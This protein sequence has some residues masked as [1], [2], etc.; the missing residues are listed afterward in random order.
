MRRL[1][2]IARDVSYEDALRE[3]LL[4]LTNEYTC[5]YA[6]DESRGDFKILLPIAGD[7]FVLDVGC[8]WGAVA[9]SLARSCGRLVAADT[10]LETLEFLKI[11]AEQEGVD[12]IT[13]IRIDPLDFAN[14]PFLDASVDTVV[15]NGV[16]E[17]V[18][19][20]R[21]DIPPRSVQLACLRE[22]KRL[23]APGGCLYIGIENRYGYRYFG[24]FRDHSGLPFTSLVP[25][26]LAG[27]VMRMLRGRGYRT[28]TYTYSGYKS[29]LREAGFSHISFYHPIP[30]YRN[31]DY[32]MPLEQRNAIKYYV[33][34][35]MS[36]PDSPSV[37]RK[38]LKKVIKFVLPVI[39]FKYLAF[40]YSIVAKVTV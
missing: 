4:P 17:W 36:V 26:V 2:D 22:M 32:L 6:T 15:M 39:P 16:L 18:G 29:L 7:S 10:T 35:L 14:L 12:N 5:G 30:T 21:Q 31:P 25:R 8:G 1:L 19:N 9:I 27:L 13:L 28:Y 33:K 38:A 40:S 3:V 23:I 20:A 11:R 37:K 24:G 34:H